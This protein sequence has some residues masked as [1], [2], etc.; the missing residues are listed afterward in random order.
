MYFGS[1]YYSAF[2]YCNINRK[3]Y[4]KI[5][6]R[7]KVKKKKKKPGIVPLYEVQNFMASTIV[8]RLSI[9]FLNKI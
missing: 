7:K 9:N 6:Q 2:T 8:A 3:V 5:S 4:K 1:A